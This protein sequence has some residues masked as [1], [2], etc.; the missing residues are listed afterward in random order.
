VLL[1]SA[2][3]GL[4]ELINKSKNGVSKPSANKEYDE[5]SNILKKQGLS[6]KDVKE[7]IDAKKLEKFFNNKEGN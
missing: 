7:I 6:D 2:V 5:I 3:W 1:I 4:M